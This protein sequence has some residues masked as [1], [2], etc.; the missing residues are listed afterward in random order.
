ME[1][2][3][4]IHHYIPQFYA[5]GFTDE[6]RMFYVYDK[7][8]D[9][10][11]SNR[12]SPKSVFYERDRNT[13]FTADGETSILEDKL[14]SDL[15][16]RCASAVI[17]L[18][19]LHN[20]KESFNIEDI[21]FFRFFAINLLWRIPANDGMY[22]DFY[23]RTEIIFRDAEG[24]QV[25]DPDLLE[26]IKNDESHKKMTRFIVPTKIVMEVMANLKG[27][28]HGTLTDMGLQCFLLTDNPIVFKKTPKTTEELIK[29]EFLIPL[30]P[31]RIYSTEENATL[32]FSRNMTISFNI[33]QIL[34][35]SQYVCSPNLHVLKETI[36]L[37]KSAIMQ[38][39]LLRYMHTSL[40]N[41]IPP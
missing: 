3:S 1:K 40:F 28:A 14:Y 21:S 18:R 32:N 27:T 25:L 16:N 33:L 20:T 2:K 29:S 24:N 4:T 34:Q 39:D 15:D 9:E 30:S 41:K 10:I 36:K 22:N 26:K 38:P 6:D 35:S 13:T 23:E 5:R 12:R 17:S 37:Y 31:T 8:K 11:I 19:D 7:K